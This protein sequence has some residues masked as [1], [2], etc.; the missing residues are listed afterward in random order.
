MT[1]L[2]D[3]INNQRVSID[4]IYEVKK[5]PEKNE[6]VTEDPDEIA[7]ID[8]EKSQGAEVNAV[9]DQVYDRLLNDA[10]RVRSNK[11]E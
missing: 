11:Q 8:S 9:V 7:S 5:K 2:I 4:K 6:E 1:D 10:Q 3:N